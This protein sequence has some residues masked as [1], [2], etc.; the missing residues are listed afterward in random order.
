MGKLWKGSTATQWEQTISG[1]FLAWAL[2]ARPLNPIK[3]PVASTGG[4]L[5]IGTVAPTTCV[6][7]RHDGT[8]VRHHPVDDKVK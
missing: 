3:T 6:S 4:G 7:R 8:V 2:L 5:T 1:R